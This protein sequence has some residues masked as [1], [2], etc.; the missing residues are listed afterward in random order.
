MRFKPQCKG[1]FMQTGVTTRYGSKNKS[2]YKVVGVENH[3]PA[4]DNTVHPPQKRL[5]LMFKMIPPQAAPIPGNDLYMVQ[6]CN[7]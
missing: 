5:I 1:I 3:N 6:P 2:Y 7:T 4:A